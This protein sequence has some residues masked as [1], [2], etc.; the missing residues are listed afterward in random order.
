MKSFSQFQI[1]CIHCY[2]KVNQFSL[3][4]NNEPCSIM[5]IFVIESNFFVQTKIDLNKLYPSS[6]ILKLYFILNG[7]KTLIIV[8]KSLNINKYIEG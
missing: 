5:K 7:F 6:L 1:E 8:K 4:L 3:E 2:L